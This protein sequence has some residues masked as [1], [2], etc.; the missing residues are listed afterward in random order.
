MSKTVKAKNI[1]AG[2]WIVSRD[3]RGNERVLHNQPSVKGRRFIRTSRFD[4]NWS[5][6]HKVVLVDEPPECDYNGN[7]IKEPSVDLDELFDMQEEFESIIDEIR[8]KVGELEELSERL[9]E[10]IDDLD[11]EV[12]EKGTA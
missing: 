2:D 1:K 12:Y 4:H 9:S 8:S 7:L 10:Y 3:G 5:N 6:D 11:D